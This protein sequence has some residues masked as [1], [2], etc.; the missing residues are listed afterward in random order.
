MITQSV[1][2]SFDYFKFINYSCHSRST[3]SYFGQLKEEL[4]T[5]LRVGSFIVCIG[6]SPIL[7]WANK[8]SIRDDCNDGYDKIS[9]SYIE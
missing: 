9:Y 6:V 7:L 2:L 8:A 5:V 3:T 1:S 4:S